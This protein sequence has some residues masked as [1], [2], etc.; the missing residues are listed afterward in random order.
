MSG[1][2]ILSV[3]TIIYLITPKSKHYY[4]QLNKDNK[5]KLSWKNILIGL[6]KR[7][8]NLLN[9]EQNNTFS[10]EKYYFTDPTHASYKGAKLFSK[11]L[12]SQINNL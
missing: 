1:W 6:E 2:E 3:V 12:K 9:Y 11:V 8:V 4:D 5:A 7:K 10:D